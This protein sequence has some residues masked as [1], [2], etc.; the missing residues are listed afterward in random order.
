[1]TMTAHAR[2]NHYA[3]EEAAPEP[4]KAS[5]LTH[6]VEWLIAMRTS[7]ANAFLS[8]HCYLLARP[9]DDKPTQ[10]PLS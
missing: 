7:Q 3:L 8:E 5:W 2:S 4:R 6:L 10:A 1:M 9:P